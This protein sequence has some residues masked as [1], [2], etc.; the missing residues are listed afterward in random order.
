[1]NGFCF[2]PH[3]RAEFLVRLANEDLAPMFWILRIF[4]AARGDV[5]TALRC[6]YCGWIYHGSAG[7]LVP[8]HWFAG[9]RCQGS[10]RRAD[11]CWPEL[12]RRRC[13]LVRQGN[14]RRADRYRGC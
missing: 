9:A 11:S 1:M 7:H 13:K 2:C 12:N 8:S 14:R 10:L 3:C 5:M 6:P 4:A